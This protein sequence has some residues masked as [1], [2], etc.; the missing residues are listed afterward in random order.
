M[1]T[2][3]KG[4]TLI[5][6]MIVVAIIG[7]LAAIA[8]PAYQDY[9]IRAQVSEGLT[10]ASDVKAG[11]AE[12]MAQTGDWPVDAGRSRPR[13][14]AAHAR[15]AGSLCHGR[16]T[17]RTA[18]STSSYGHDAN[19]K[20][21]GSHL[22]IQPLVN[23]ER[24][25]RVALRQCRMRRRTPATPDAG[26][27]RTDSAATA[28]RRCPT[29]TCRPRAA[30]AS[31]V[32]NRLDGIAGNRAGP[33]KAPACRGLAFCASVI[34]WSRTHECTGA[35][36][37]QRLGRHCL[38]PAAR[39]AL[40][41]GLLLV[42]G[43]GGRL[44]LRQPASPDV[45]QRRAS[46]SGR[47]S[48][49]N[50]PCLPAQPGSCTRSSARSSAALALLT[51][52]AFPRGVGARRRLLVAGWFMIARRPCARG[53]HDPVSRFGF[54]GRRL[55]VARSRSLGLLPVEIALAALAVLL[56][57]L[58]VRARRASA[59]VAQAPALATMAAAAGRA[60][61]SWRSPR[62][63]G[64]ASTP[65]ASAAPHII[66]LGIDSLR[67]DLQVPRRGEPKTPGIA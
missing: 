5:E 38:E 51:E 39:L 8:I 57:W 1:K 62:L 29:S 14:S 22:A 44:R 46:T 61:H 48:P 45:R 6:L 54:F 49:A 40:P 26:A 23:D 21:Q 36:A 58:V 47:S 20:I 55:L 53:E 50:S 60:L 30:R 35:I 65:I 10:L 59:C 19:A 3:Q 67:N 15:Q 37:S 9:T 42:G 18:R 4:F 25:R 63:L 24:R 64:A 31:A 41:R 34:G 17:S 2:F 43:A 32:R 16:S 66:I 13:L 33:G 12:Y 56:V 28:S 27:V 52:A 11:V 7:I